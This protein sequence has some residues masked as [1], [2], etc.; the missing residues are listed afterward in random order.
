MFK[1]DIAYPFSIQ[2]V[3]EVFKPP[4]LVLFLSEDSVLPQNFL[5]VADVHELHGDPALLL[6]LPH[7]PVDELLLPVR[8]LEHHGEPITVQAVSSLP[9]G[10][11]P[12]M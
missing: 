10:L 3:L 4:L 12:R 1:G 5:L 6:G 8:L 2:S 9:P 7:E 11:K